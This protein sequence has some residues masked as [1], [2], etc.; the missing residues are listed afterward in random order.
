MRTRV[1]LLRLASAAVLA[2]ALATAAPARA[3][4][5]DCVEVVAPAKPLQDA[6]EAAANAAQCVGQ[7][8]SGDAV[9]IAAIGAIT[10]LR[11]GGAFS[12]TAECMG[13]I[14]SMIGKTVAQALL[15]SGL[16]D[17][18][19]TG[20][21]SPQKTAIKNQLQQVV[22]GKLSLTQLANSVPALKPLLNYV[23]CGCQIAGLDGEMSV[24]ANAYKESVEGCAEFA[25]DAVEFVGDAIESG[26]DAV[27]EGIKKVVEFA[28]KCLT[29]LCGL[30]DDDDAPECVIHTF[31]KS[32]F[33]SWVPQ[34]IKSVGSC[35][36]WVCDQGGH[37]KTQIKGGKAWST[38]SHCY[39]VWALD[40]SGKCAPCGGT[41]K[42]ISKNMCLQKA[43]SY[44]TDDGA[45]CTKTPPV[46]ESCCVAGQLMKPAKGWNGGAP[47]CSKGVIGGECSNLAMASTQCVGAC[48][49]PQY[50]DTGTGLCTDC[51]FNSVPVYDSDPTKS[52]VG[53]CKQC[54]PGLTGEASLTCEPCAAGL[55]IWSLTPPKK[56]NG[57][58]TQ[59]QAGP[60]S[61]PQ[62]SPT[63]AVARLP[64]PRQ[65]AAGTVTALPGG[66]FGL[67]EGGRC[68]AC[69][70]NW[71]PVYYSDPTK[72]SFGY[73]KE[74]P[75][76]HY[77][78]TSIQA[79]IKDPIT[80]QWLAAPKQPECLPCPAGFD[81]KH[82]HVCLPPHTAKPVSGVI[83]GQTEC[84]P[85]MQLVDGVCTPLSSTLVPRGRLVCP[86]GQLPNATRT[87]CIAIS[88][89]Q[90]ADRVATKAPGGQTSTA[91]KRR[92]SRWLVKPRVS[93]RAKTLPVPR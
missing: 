57:L 40:G 39:G 75:P 68:V 86:P 76:G 80:G 87:G 16:A 24:I 47:D 35:G 9:M 23:T 73:C 67:A 43:T 38:C 42:T 46:D 44:A 31:P 14:N 82:P 49:P 78:P 37:P 6:V 59:K 90:P 88:R 79:P 21:S 71:Q 10:A 27:G 13:M 77:L 28:E 93:P 12:N 54:P 91:A 7:A 30:F 61:G 33:G 69:P 65:A 22:E 92:P 58:A 62:H 32:K 26:I 19:L 18:L 53:Q 15:E 20:L 11:A 50:F 48:F 89:K 66:L 1:G 51:Q 70:E 25:S 63:D 72:S 45:S 84:P 85:G 36:E 4:I 52:S 41:V 8:A 2:G 60:L 5:L 83:S 74:C 34:D 56:Q 55:L 17:V 29:D 3:G 81:P 64:P